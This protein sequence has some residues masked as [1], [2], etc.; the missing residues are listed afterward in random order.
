MLLIFNNNCK[1]IF[2]KLKTWPIFSL[3]FCYYNLNL[4]I[5]LETNTSNKVIA[6]ILLQLYLDNK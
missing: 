2:K 5:I 6:R 3:I 4:K 1:E